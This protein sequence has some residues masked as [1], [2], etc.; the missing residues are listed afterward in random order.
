MQAAQGTDV[1]YIAVWIFK[2]AQ[3]PGKIRPCFYIWNPAL[4]EFFYDALVHF[5]R[6]PSRVSRQH[7]QLVGYENRRYFFRINA[8]PVVRNNSGDIIF[9]NPLPDYFFLLKNSLN[10][11]WRIFY[12][13]PFKESAVF[14]IFDVVGRKLQALQVR[15]FFLKH[16]QGDSVGSNDWCVAVIFECLNNRNASCSVS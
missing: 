12:H 8:K 7:I 13:F 2:M 15:K 4:I 6:N 16:L 1:F 9:R 3:F 11:F 5:A 14:G 10:H